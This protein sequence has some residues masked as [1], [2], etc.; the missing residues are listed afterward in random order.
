M[1]DIV[2]QMV[3]NGKISKNTYI[4]ST[5]GQ[6]VENGKFPKNTDVVSFYAYLLC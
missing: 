5:V 4:V 2:G 3:E 1:G 6:V